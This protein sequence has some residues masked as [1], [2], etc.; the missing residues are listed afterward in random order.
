MPS[1][2][3]FPAAAADPS[4]RRRRRAVSTGLSGQG[5]SA[6]C[7]G[8]V[9]PAVTRPSTPDGAG[10]GANA[11]AAGPLL[12]GWAQGGAQ[13]RSVGAAEGQG[14]GQA[15]GPGHGGGQDW[16]GGTGSAVV[17][18]G[19]GPAE[20]QGGGQDGPESVVGPHG[21]GQS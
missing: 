17:E 15:F 14:G 10:Q 13:G 9:G 2:A 1:A 5:S 12:A 8:Q 6:R 4:W 3:D 16:L 20:A 7:T 18:A 19:A 21:G 11:P